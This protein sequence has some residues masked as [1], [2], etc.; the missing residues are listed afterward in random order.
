MPPTTPDEVA[1][2]ARLMDDPDRDVQAA[3]Q[4]RLDALGPDAL[5]HLRAAREATPDDALRRTLDTL[6]HDL[7]L[8]TV[9]GAW[10]SVMDADE[11]DLERGA[12][13]LALYRFPDLDVRRYQAQLDDWA[14]EVASSM[15]RF[16]GAERAVRLAQFVA[17]DLGFEGNRAQY[18]DPN[19]SYL[20]RVLD[21]RLGIPISLSVVCL[22]LGQRL[23]LPVYGVSLPAHF[24]VK[25]V[26]ARGE[27]F[28]DLFGGG[29][30][31]TKDACVR[32]LL[33]AGIK[34][35][36]YFFESVGAQE[37]LLRM[38]RNLW[39]IA[40]EAGQTQTAADLERLLAPWD[41]NW[42]G[43]LED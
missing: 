34:P 35:R 18:Y 4:T 20:N 25:Y 22:L 40:Q 9:V 5:P 3:V 11:V 17:E 13:L 42:E 24:L 12:L 19:N 37:I 29:V 31:V 33:K 30:P 1:A 2:L 43:G 41:P 36:G 16:T 7:H 39:G 38:V 14:G 28:I 23:G 26:D 27:L 10:T 32:F 6:V 8:R 15:D 21:R